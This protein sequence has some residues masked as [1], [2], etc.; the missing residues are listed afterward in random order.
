MNINRWLKLAVALP[1]L[2]GSI[3]AQVPAKPTSPKAASGAQP[4]QPTQEELI[5]MRDEKL[6][7]PVFKKANWTFD[8][9]AARAESKQSG[10]PIFVYFSRSYAH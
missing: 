8:Y 4:K 5:V 6:A 2:I 7:L 10:K 3:S 9:D 1:A